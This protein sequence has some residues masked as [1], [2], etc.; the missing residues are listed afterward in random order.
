MEERP[1]APKSL[2]I[3]DLQD[4]TCECGSSMLR[5][6]N[7]IFFNFGELKCCDK[8][9]EINKPKKNKVFNFKNW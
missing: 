1:K 5:K 3:C 4:A 8:T 2:W 6:Y 7:L 9:C